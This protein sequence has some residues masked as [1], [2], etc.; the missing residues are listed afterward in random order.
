MF[1]SLCSSNRQTMI[2]NIYKWYAHVYIFFFQAI[3]KNDDKWY[4]IYEGYT[5]AYTPFSG[6]RLTNDDESYNYDIY[7]IY[8]FI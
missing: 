6:N 3:D 1:T 7:R 2:N 8:S 5:H 4:I